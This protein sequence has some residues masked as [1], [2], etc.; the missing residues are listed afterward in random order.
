MNLFAPV[1]PP[2]AQ[3]TTLYIVV[4]YEDWI[5]TESQGSKHEAIFH[6]LV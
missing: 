2:D 4:Y 3:G 1:Q 5:H 6:R